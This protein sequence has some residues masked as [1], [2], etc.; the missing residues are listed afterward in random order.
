MFPIES[1]DPIAS[2]VRIGDDLLVTNR[3]VVGA[4]KNATI[5]TPTG[6][7]TVKVLVSNSWRSR[8]HS[9][10]GTFIGRPGLKDG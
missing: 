10:R 5:F 8:A 3:R 6:Q 1:F 4:R 9:G 7:A 2:A